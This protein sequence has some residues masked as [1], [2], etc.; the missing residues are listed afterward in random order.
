ML[1]SSKTLNPIYCLKSLQTYDFSPKNFYLETRADR[2][3]LICKMWPVRRTSR[4]Y[5]LLY[6]ETRANMI[7]W[8]LAVDWSR[9]IFQTVAGLHVAAS[10]H[11]VRPSQPTRSSPTHSALGEYVDS[12][13]LSR[14]KVRVFGIFLH[15][16]H[17]NFLKHGDWL[18]CFILS[19]LGNPWFESMEDR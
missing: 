12:P 15:S 4:S 8:L 1:A 19:E 16:C 3:Y 18:P 14:A 7:I 5:D 10:R 9:I 11:A 2:C 17:T 13:P 6:L